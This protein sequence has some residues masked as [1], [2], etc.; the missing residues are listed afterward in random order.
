MLA[1]IMPASGL[2]LQVVM[3]T[4][5]YGI[6]TNRDIISTSGGEM[7]MDNGNR[8]MAARAFQR[9]MMRMVIAQIASRR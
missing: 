7:V 1:L 8:Q 9:S 3:K 4:W 2:L 5:K 6:A